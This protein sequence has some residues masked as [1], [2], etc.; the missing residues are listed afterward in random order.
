M[1]QL[2]KVK[3]PDESVVN[4]PR[5]PTMGLSHIYHDG[6]TPTVYKLIARDPVDYETFERHRHV[7]LRSVVGQI[8]RYV[9]VRKCCVKSARRYFGM[10]Y[11]ACGFA[12]DLY[13][14]TDELRLEFNCGTLLGR[15]E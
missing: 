14:A 5:A 8:L 10:S 4:L 13:Q 15:L 6:T 9:T 12:H 11:V 3:L 1:Y 2:S 7:I